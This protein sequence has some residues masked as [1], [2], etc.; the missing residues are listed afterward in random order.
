MQTETRAWKGLQS[1]L[2]DW[3][4]WFSELSE[5]F[6]PNKD[7]VQDI[8]R[9]H[10]RVR[11]GCERQLQSL[12]QE[13]VPEC[14]ECIDFE[15]EAKR[16]ARCKRGTLP[17]LQA[18]EMLENKNTN[19]L[20]LWNLL[21]QVRIE[22]AQLTFPWLPYAYLNRSDRDPTGA[23]QLYEQQKK[24]VPELICRLQEQLENTPVPLVEPKRTQEAGLNVRTSRLVL[25]SSGEVD[26]HGNAVDAEG[27]PIVSP[28]E[29]CWEPPLE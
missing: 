29:I 7:T 9:G 8:W 25:D 16:P 27:I 13:A 3:S 17:L 5:A 26:R 14:E 28:K 6:T 20:P 2:L 4:D 15:P 22:A 21:K 1:I 12:F 24:R 18:E 19:C 11:D 23:Q 10:N